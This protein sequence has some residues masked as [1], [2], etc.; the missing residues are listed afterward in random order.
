MRLSWSDGSL[1][2][3]RNWTLVHVCTDLA[4]NSQLANRLVARLLGPLLEM[5]F[6]EHEKALPMVVHV[7]HVLTTVLRNRA[8]SNLAVAHEAVSFDAALTQ[9]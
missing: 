4:L 5:V 3:Q 9:L 7:V 6:D 8:A 1:F 2:F